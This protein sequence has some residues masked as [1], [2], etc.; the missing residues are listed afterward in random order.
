MIKLIICWVSGSSSTSKTE[1]G[2]MVCCPLLVGRIV[3]C[4]SLRACG[5]CLDTLIRGGWAGGRLRFR[6]GRTLRLFLEKDFGNISDE[7]TGTERL[8]EIGVETGGQYTLTIPRHRFGSGSDDDDGF[9]L[10]TG[11]N[12][13]EHLPAGH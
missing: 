9:E 5:F 8:G 11:T 2:F 6:L 4:L 12:R 1:M 10:V 3:E 13:A 7:R